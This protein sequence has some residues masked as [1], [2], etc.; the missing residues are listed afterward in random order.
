[1]YWRD[2]KVDYSNINIE[3]NIGFESNKILGKIISEYR[4]RYMLKNDRPYNRCQNRKVKT[5]HY[6]VWLNADKVT[7]QSAKDMGKFVMI[8]QAK[9][10][11]V[12]YNE[13]NM[14]SIPQKTHFHLI[15]PIK[16]NNPITKAKEKIK[17][18]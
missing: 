2:Y 17:D 15:R 1:M 9:G 4:D 3:T 5:E 6:T 7:A 11:T 12:Q 18:I 8:W 13:P 10:F 16:S 14:Q